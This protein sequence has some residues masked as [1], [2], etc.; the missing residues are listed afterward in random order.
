MSDHSPV[1]VADI[2]GTNARFGIAS[3]GEKITVEQIEILATADYDSLQSAA[4]HYLS[5]TTGPRPAIGSVAIAG[6]VANEHVQMTNCPWSF[7]RSALASELEMERVSV[8]NDFEAIA[9]ALPF[10]QQSDLM[11]IGRG[12]H[13]NGNKVVIGP[14][15]GIGVAA[16]TPVGLG[17]KVL[18]SEGGHIGFSPADDLERQL[19]RAVKH[20]YARVSVERIISGQGFSNLHQ[21]LATLKGH[22]VDEMTPMEI[23]REAIENPQGHCGEVVDIF[24]GILGSFAGDMAVIFNATDGVYLAGGIL[25]KIQN[26]FLNSR[27]RERFENKGRLD[28]VK[29]IPT[30]QIMEKQPA[31]LGAAAHIQGEFY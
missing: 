25:P 15:T 2:G 10:L 8:L 7:K 22:E 9:C 11:Q 24:C 1:L 17:W 27:F 19:L 18:A 29:D 12:S 28:F 6:F 13:K 30:L 16:L 23:T 4:Q 26:F 5:K 14:G 31:L 21:A 3:I 20:K